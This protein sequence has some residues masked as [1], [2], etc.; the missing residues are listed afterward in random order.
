MLKLSRRAMVSCGRGQV[1]TERPRTEGSLPAK[2]N[3]VKPGRG[4]IATWY[5]EATTDSPSW[6]DLRAANPRPD[7]CAV[8]NAVSPGLA[9]ASTHKRHQAPGKGSLMPWMNPGVVIR[10]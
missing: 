7:L 8:A 9:Y 5:P 1:S 10:G 6:A 3:E 2:E 4:Q